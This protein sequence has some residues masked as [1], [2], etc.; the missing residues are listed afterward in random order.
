MDSGAS[1]FV[2]FAFTLL[3]LMPLRSFQIYHPTLQ[4]WLRTSRGR[5]FFVRDSWEP[6]NIFRYIIRYLLS[7]CT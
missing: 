7:F 4:R 3:L 1:W 6:M 5:Y 2:F